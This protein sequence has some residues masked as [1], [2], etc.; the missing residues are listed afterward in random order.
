MKMFFLGLSV[1]FILGLKQCNHPV[2]SL[3]K[4]DRHNNMCWVSQDENIGQPIC[5]HGVPN[6]WIIGYYMLNTHDL[7]RVVDRLTWCEE[8]EARCRGQCE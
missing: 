8:F 4:A 7:K 1:A 3:C 2:E 5:E 6:D